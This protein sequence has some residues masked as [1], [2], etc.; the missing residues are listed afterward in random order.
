MYV[1]VDTWVVLLDVVLFSIFVRVFFFLSLVSAVT[2]DEWRFIL[3]KRDNQLEDD[4]YDI[5]HY[6]L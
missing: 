5:Y 6:D 1:Y 2:V 4:H 3:H